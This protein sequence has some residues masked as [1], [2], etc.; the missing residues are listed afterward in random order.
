MDPLGHFG[1]KSECKTMQLNRFNCN[2]GKAEYT[3][4]TFDGSLFFAAVV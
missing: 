2:A 1:V 4:K 3:V